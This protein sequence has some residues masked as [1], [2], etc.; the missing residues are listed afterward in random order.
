MRLKIISALTVAMFVWIQVVT[1]SA[2]SAPEPPES[3]LANRW[4]SGAPRTVSG[5]EKNGVPYALLGSRNAVLL[6]DLSDPQPKIPSLVLTAP[7][8]EKVRQFP[9]AYRHR[10]SH[11]LRGNMS[12]PDV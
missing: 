9:T 4:P 10:R 6:L 2:P 8:M 3:T 12:G 5:F 11:S 1:V 7:A